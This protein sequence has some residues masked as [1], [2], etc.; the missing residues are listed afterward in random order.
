MTGDPVLNEIY[1]IRAELSDQ[2]QGDVHALGRYLREQQSA[3]GA[4]VVTRSPKPVKM[5]VVHN[6]RLDVDRIRDN[7]PATTP[8]ITVAQ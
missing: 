2:F 4:T 7:T 3:S 6:P 1:R 8:V 5:G